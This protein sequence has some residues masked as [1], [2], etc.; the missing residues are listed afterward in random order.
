MIANQNVAE[1]HTTEV[2]QNPSLWSYAQVTFIERAE[3]EQ[4]WL[5]PFWH[6]FLL[7]FF[8][9][10][11]VHTLSRTYHGIHLLALTAKTRQHLRHL[12][13]QGKKDSQCYAI[14]LIIPSAA[15]RRIL[16][17]RLTV[18]CR[19]SPSEDE[20]APLENTAISWV[21][22]TGWGQTAEISDGIVKT[23]KWSC[24]CGC[25]RASTQQFSHKFK[26]Q[27]LIFKQKIFPLFKGHKSKKKIIK[28]KVLFH[29]Y[30]YIYIHMAVYN[31]NYALNSTIVSFV[32]KHHHYVIICNVGVF[33]I[34][35]KYFK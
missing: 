26:A 14:L 13:Q 28:A 33:E 15:V 35:L 7:V 29:L 19:R 1:F 18:W 31:V 27:F 5:F 24:Q 30:I 8:P 12:T 21:Y 16:T 4:K 22:F 34:K 20:P 6:R 23:P 2:W 32:M 25:E 11:E 9:V 3:S 17:G 10:K